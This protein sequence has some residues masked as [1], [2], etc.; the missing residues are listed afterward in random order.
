VLLFAGTLAAVV[1]ARS[2]QDASGA[3]ERVPGSSAIVAAHRAWGRRA[4]NVFLAMA[5]LEA[6]AL[7]DRRV[8][9]ASALV[10]IAGLACLLAAG[11]RGGELVYRYAGGVGIRSGDPAD[12][13]RLLLAGLY[14]QADAD[15]RAGRDD[16]AAVLAALA[17]RIRGRLAQSSSGS[18][19]YWSPK[20]GVVDADGP[21]SRDDGR[22][23]AHGRA[24][25]A[26][27]RGGGG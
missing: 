7:A 18:P 2:A 22:S 12:V 27:G 14:H 8:R 20:A 25:R 9:R 13:T 19:V 26:P 23:G 6:I 17:T 5:A 15:R 10:G 3:V 4:R 24:A 1:A 11:A 21:I 16:E